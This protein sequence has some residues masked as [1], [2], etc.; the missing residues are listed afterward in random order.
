ML[1]VLDNSK[2]AENVKQ[3]KSYSYWHLIRGKN[4]ILAK[5]K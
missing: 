2:L 3:A 1:V 5:A 4:A